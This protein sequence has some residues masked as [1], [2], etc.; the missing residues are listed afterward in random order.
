M[1]ALAGS[2]VVDAQE[3]TRTSG[4]PAPFTRS[5][6][7]PF[8]GFL[9]LPGP[10]AP[11]TPAPIPARAGTIA[12]VMAAAPAR[13]PQAARIADLSR[14]SFSRVRALFACGPDGGRKRPR[15][16]TAFT[17]TSI[18]THVTCFT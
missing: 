8:G 7:K 11:A 10:Q 3:R 9:A 15:L 12:T 2:V 1:G 13:L 5:D 6:L 18:V 4:I 14:F 16:V 17:L